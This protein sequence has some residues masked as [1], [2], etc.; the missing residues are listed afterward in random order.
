MK[1]RKINYILKLGL[2]LVSLTSFFACSSAPSS[3]GPDF[4]GNYPPQVLEKMMVNIV[5]EKTNNLDPI[6]ITY[7][8][9]PKNN[10]VNLHMR[11]D[12]NLV[13]L[14]LSRSNR[15]TWLG[16]M[17]QYIS[18]YQSGV[19]PRDKSGSSAYFG[20]MKAPISW[21]VMT[22][23]YNAIPNFRFEYRY[24]TKE[25]PYFELN[26]E[27]VPPL[28]SDGNPIKNSATSS[29]ALKIVF[30]P[31]QCQHIIDILKQEAL[32]KIVNDL[33]AERNK[34]DIPPATESST[35]DKKEMF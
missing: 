12:L 11:Y 16:S 32:T 20:S 7:V 24:I 25:K 27:M 10:T 23:A 8:F 17:Q 4:L 33:D 35:S 3:T 28:D 9:Y 26:G 22:T 5:N 13:S 21:G 18:D 30:T 29:P 1:L 31:L 34:F 19:L 14:T 2:L 6:E 15:D